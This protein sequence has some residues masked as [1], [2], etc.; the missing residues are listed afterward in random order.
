MPRP[1]GSSSRLA[2]PFTCKAVDHRAFEAFEA[3]R[4]E[5]EDLRHVI[6]RLERVGVAEARRAPGAADSRSASPSRRAR[7]RRCLRCR[8]A[9]ARRGIRSRAAARRGCSR[10][11]A[12][13]ILG[14][15]ARIAIGV[16]DRAARA[17][18]SRCRAR[19][20]PCARDRLE[21]GVAGRADGQLGAVVEQDAQLLDVVDRLAG[22]QRVRAARVVADHAAERAAAVRRRIGTERQLVRLGAVAQACRARRPA[23]R[24]RTAVPDRSRGS[25]SCIS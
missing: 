12:V 4:R 6:G 15:F 3:D 14:N 18:S 13:G 1:A 16:L 9:R 8:P 17:A 21:L 25:G 2:A 20:P 23:G 24:A 19:R 5:L 10:R 7:S 11:R 22:Q